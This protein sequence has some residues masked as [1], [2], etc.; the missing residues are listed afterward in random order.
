MF[1]NIYEI[2]FISDV[3][4]YDNNWLLLLYE[5]D[6]ITLDVVKFYIIVYLFLRPYELLFLFVNI[7]GGVSPIDN[8]Y[9]IPFFIFI[10]LLI[11]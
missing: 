2:F 8:D 1:Y 10:I 7:L 4:P 6:P 11:V 9:F 3:I 5:V